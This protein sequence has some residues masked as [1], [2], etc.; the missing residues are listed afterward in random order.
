MLIVVVIIFVISALIII[1]IGFSIVLVVSIVIIVLS[2]SIVVVLSIVIVPLLMEV[3]SESFLIDLVLVFPVYSSFSSFFSICAVGDV[4][5]E[6][7]LSVTT[8]L[9][10]TL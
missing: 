3:A 9:F 6:V 2:A 1:I 8:A 4:I 7:L 10:C 5:E